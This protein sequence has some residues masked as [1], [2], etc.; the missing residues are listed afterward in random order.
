MKTIE[1]PVEFDINTLNVGD[2]VMVNHP[3]IK[4]PFVVVPENWPHAH[5]TVIRP[6]PGKYLVLSGVDYEAELPPCFSVGAVE[7]K[8]YEVSIVAE[9]AEIAIGKV[10]VRS[11]K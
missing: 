4:G 9:H 10:S 7:V 2:R 3:F 11:A 6:A 1:Y 8:E 5:G